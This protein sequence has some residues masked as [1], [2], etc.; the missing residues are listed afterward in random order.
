MGD[1]HIWGCKGSAIRKG[2]RVVRDILFS[3]P[4]IGL[5]ESSGAKKTNR[6]FGNVIS[7]E[8]D[9]MFMTMVNKNTPIEHA[10]NHN[11]IDTG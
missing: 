8:V 11:S 1:S 4:T 2:E 5:E 7:L 3:V 6:S 9:G 10:F